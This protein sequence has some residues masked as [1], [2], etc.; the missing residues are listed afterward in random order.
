MVG[1]IGIDCGVI[2]VRDSSDSQ[3]SQVWRQA[4]ILFRSL[5]ETNSQAGAMPQ[6]QL[7]MFPVG[8]TH[9]TPELAFERR[10]GRV[11]YFLG[12]TPVMQHAVDDIR[13]F[14]MF[15]SQLIVNGT[16][17]QRDIIRTFGLPP[18][19]VKRAVKKYRD[20]G[21]ASFFA[22]RRTRGPS[23]LTKDVLEKL[24]E[25]LDAGEPRAEAAR[26]LG[27]KP[28]TVSKAV[29]AGRLHEKRR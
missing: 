28:D 15:T 2:G 1:W 22:P 26:Q 29:R 8:V 14:R 10:D 24:Q 18:V 21:P 23:V 4:R 12:H 5:A 19:T 9:I 13:T 20:G 25:M 6:L 16:V 7:P 11:Y 3:M 17:R 27:L